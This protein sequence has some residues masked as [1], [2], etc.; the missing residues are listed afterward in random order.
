LGTSTIAEALRT[1][2][3]VVHIHDTEFKQD[4]KD[5]AWLAVVGARG[6]VVLGKDR[7]IRSRQ[8]ELVALLTAGVAAFFLTSADLSGPEMAGAFV[9]ALPKIRRILVGQR[10]PFVAAVSGVG[11]VALLVRGRPRWLQKRLAKPAPTGG[12]LP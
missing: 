4:E 2:G 11:T 10:R 7:H 8:N 1:A 9:R 5:T 3:C 6:W 12:G